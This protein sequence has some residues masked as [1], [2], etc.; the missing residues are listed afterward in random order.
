MP[1]LTDLYYVL[2]SKHADPKDRVY[3][4]VVYIAEL[5]IHIPLSYL[6][7]FAYA[8]NWRNKYL[9]EGYLCGA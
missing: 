6:V 7:Y 3:L 4:D 9:L 1:L 8:K 2:D 5:T